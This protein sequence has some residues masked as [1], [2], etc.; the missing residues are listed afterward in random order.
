MKIA[1]HGLG[2]MGLQIAR[3]LLAEQHQVVVHNRSPEP[4]QAAAEFG[5]T[6]AASKADV[7]KEFGDKPVIW[8]M[9]PADVL[10][11]ELKAWLEILPAGSTLIDGGNSDYRQT[12][13][14][15]ALAAS[16]NCDLIDVGTSGGILGFDNGFSM[17]VGGDETCFK[18][19]EP[20]LASLAKP[21]GGYCYFG[22]S[23]SGHYV[24]MV[25]NAIEYGMMESLAE[26][27][28]MLKEG[29]YA[30]IDLAAAGKVW[31]QG[32]IIAS[33][34]NELTAQ[35]LVENPTLDGIDG[36]VAES[37]EARWALE[38]ARD[39]KIDLPS[40]QAAF[41]VRLASQKGQTSLT[42]RLLALM[43]NKFGGHN[44]NK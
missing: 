26:G 14:H 30:D 42:T 13:K 1:I 27:Y 5:A 44:I 33:K 41:D 8:L 10:E 35:A 29:P 12:Q 36:Y 16:K 28:R 22:A 43:R 34:L 11:G 3:R 38:T 20:A 9:L 19:I 37:G 23:G 17:M 31:E 32:S 24:K 39:L 40:I 15:A 7:I 21:S 2:R 6:I 4:M 25:H 18:L